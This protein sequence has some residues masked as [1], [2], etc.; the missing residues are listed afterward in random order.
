MWKRLKHKN[1]VPLICISMTPF[2]L[3]S[4]WMP[5][6]DLTEYVG[7]HPEADRLSLVSVP[8]SALD[9]ALTPTASCV[10]LLRAFSFFTPATWFMAI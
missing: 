6:G 5:G 1:I 8:L 2:Q 9:Q 10:M 7:K 4:E 3:I